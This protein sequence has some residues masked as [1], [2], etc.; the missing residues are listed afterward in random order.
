[1]ARG[2]ERPGLYLQAG[3]STSSLSLGKQDPQE[4]V[5]SNSA[6]SPPGENFPQA[7]K[8]HRENAPVIPHCAYDPGGP[9]PL[10]GS[11]PILQTS[12]RGGPEGLR[13]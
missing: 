1:M 4:E 10:R 9:P 5:V 13:Y 3:L 12:P 2:T 7:R 8:S 11:T 6:F